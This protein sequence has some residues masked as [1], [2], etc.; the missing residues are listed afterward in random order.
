MTLQETVQSIKKPDEKAMEQCKK[1]WNSIA[2]PLNSLGKMEDFLVKIA[3]M[4]GS[5]QIDL[6]KKGLVIMCADNGVVEE[7]R[8]PNWPGGNG[9]CG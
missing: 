2:K 4:T 1:R 6:G 5:S 3:G 9:D 7:G 8:D